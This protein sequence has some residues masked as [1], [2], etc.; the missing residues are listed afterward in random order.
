MN[1]FI[2]ASFFF[3]S[4]FVNPRVWFTF[5]SS[6]RAVYFSLVAPSIS[7]EN[8]TL[9][10]AEVRDRAAVVK[11]TKGGRRKVT[12]NFVH[13]C[14]RRLREFA[15]SRTARRMNVRILDASTLSSRLAPCFSRQWHNSTRVE[16]AYETEQRENGGAT[17]LERE[18][19]SQRRVLS[20]SCGRETRDT[21]LY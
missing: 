13:R 12:F 21:L 3:F 7:P 16:N 8:K 6:P 2:L 19:V 17:C 10:F 1:S 14:I 4:F 9:K 15:V 11:G 5:R 20:R 18:T